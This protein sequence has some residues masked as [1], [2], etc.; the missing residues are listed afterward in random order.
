MIYHYL[1]IFFAFTLV[2][3]KQ[4]PSTN[5]DMEEVDMAYRNLAVQTCTGCHGFPEPELVDQ[6]TW[7]NYVLP[8]MGHFYGIYNNQA[9]RND[10][11][12]DG[13][14]GT[15]VLAANIFPETRQVDSLTWYRVSQYFLHH[16]PEAMDLQE[17]P[18]M[19]L[20]E[21]FQIKIPELALSPPSS[22]MVQFTDSGQVLV[23]DAHTRTLYFLNSNLELQQAARVREGAVDVESWDQ[24]WWVTV[25]GSFSPTDARDGLII[26]LPKD[27][28]VEP[29]VVISDLQRPVDALYQDFN[30]DGLMDIVICEFGKWTGSLSLYLNKGEGQ[31]VRSIIEGR[32]GAT[33]AESR[34]INGD[35]LPDIIALFGQGTEAIESFINKGDGTF[36][37]ATLLE[38]PSSFGSSYFS[39]QDLDGDGDE[40]ILYTAGDNADYLPILKPYHGVYI[41]LNKGDF[42]FEMDQFLPQNGAYKAIPADFDGDGDLDIASIS[43]FPDYTNQPQEGFVLFENR[44]D[45]YVATTVENLDLGRWI[46]MEKADYDG[47]GDEDLILGSLAFETVPVLPK[48][49]SSW[50]NRGIPFI[51]LENLKN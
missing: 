9:E 1:I 19:E 26:K 16:A 21:L 47:D 12:E 48:L 45:S 42:Q 10:L 15:E 40:D 49:E 34:D 4:E 39:L 35:G 33:K 3:C 38:F 22:T 7:R 27:G 17:L 6:A 29:S 44:G 11:I 8:R 30:N 13:S 41:Y 28:V 20:T 2:G 50:I 43:F 24:D 32:S 51:I 31:F 46:T 36:E 37:K 5:L 23:G 18:E 14:G 25:M